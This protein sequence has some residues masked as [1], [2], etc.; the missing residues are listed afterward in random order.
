MAKSL[1]TVI[2]ELDNAAIRRTP[3]GKCS[4]YDLISVVGEQ[5]NPREAWKRLLQ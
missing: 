4:V 5:K 2:P 1:K 3:D